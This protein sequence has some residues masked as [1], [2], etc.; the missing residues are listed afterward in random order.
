MFRLKKVIGEKDNGQPAECRM[1]ISELFFI[2]F[3]R[4]ELGAHLKK[5]YYIKHLLVHPNLDNCLL[6]RATV[7]FAFFNNGKR[8]FNDFLSCDF[9]YLG[10][11]NF[12][13]PVPEVID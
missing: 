10:W 2:V 7:S 11:A 12:N 8:F 4:S 9:F 3:F 13:R 6:R 1:S 5:H